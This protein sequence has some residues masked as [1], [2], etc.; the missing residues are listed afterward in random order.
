LDDCFYQFDTE[1]IFRSDSFYPAQFLL[2]CFKDSLEGFETVEGC[3]CGGLTIL[4]G[5]AE[6]EK[7]FDHFVIVKTGQSRGDK[8]LP[9]PLSMSL[10]LV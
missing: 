3:F 1:H 6:G 8:F 5:R 2:R 7:K 4:P 10:T 9:E